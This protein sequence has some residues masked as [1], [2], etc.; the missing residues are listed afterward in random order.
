MG[1]IVLGKEDWVLAIAGTLEPST[2]RTTDRILTLS[3]VSYPLL[4]CPI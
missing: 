3:E 2:R 4:S 1:G